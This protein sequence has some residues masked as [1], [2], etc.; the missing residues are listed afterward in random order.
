MALMRPI[1]FCS[2]LA[3]VAWSFALSAVRLKAHADDQYHI[4][5]FQISI[6]HRKKQRVSSPFKGWYHKTVAVIFMKF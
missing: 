5:A 3:L 4:C 6:S 1:V 2:I